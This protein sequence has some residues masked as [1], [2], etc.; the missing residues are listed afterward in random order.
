MDN[1]IQTLLNNI[2][3][4]LQQDR[5]RK[6]ESRK[7]GEQFNVFEVLG[8]QT[9]EVRLHSAFIAELINPQGSHGLGS[10]FLNAFV[11]DVVKK[12]KSFELNIATSRITPEYNIG[13]I[14]EDY[15]DGGRIDILVQD[16][17]GHLVIIE[18][19]IYAGDQ[20]CQLLRYHNY[21]ERHRKLDQEK[22]I[23]LYLTLYDG[24]MPSDGSI[25]DD[26]FEY[27]C[28]SYRTHILNWLEKC[29][30]LASR[31]PLIRETIQQ[32]II[33]LKNILSIMANNDLER[34]LEIL[35]SK[36]NVF[37]TISI[38]ESSWSI[39]NIIR[40][41]LVKEIKTFCNE[42]GLLCDYDEGVVNC[43]N[44]TWIRIWDGKYSDVFFRIGTY[45]HSNQDGYR[46]DFFIPST[47]KAKDDFCFIFWA[48]GHK[49]NDDNPAGWIY[50]WSE[51]GKP[52]SGRWWRWDD[53][54]TLKDM[55]N[56]KMMSFFRETIC[57]I[58]EREC[59]KLISEALE[60]KPT[61]LSK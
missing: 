20:P 42:I 55:A 22:Y 45:S 28:I 49:S 57:Q 2:D 38:L 39:Q 36:E 33:N 19:K 8:V 50:L 51:S 40:T 14:S 12:C 43:V 32:Y 15:R 9:S 56:G 18:N 25:G 37:T 58:R 44:N 10:K 48:E 17:Y 4:I 23:L 7:R 24:N 13:P 27:F 21:A 53:W 59:F 16:E 3:I 30:E 11:E 52:G 46:M 54:N 60:N 31:F 41:K 5:V 34:Y 61:V 26:P 47:K 1:N 6:E 29:V 35:T